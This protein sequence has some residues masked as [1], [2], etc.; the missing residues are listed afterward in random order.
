VITT[1]DKG[2]TPGSGGGF[3]AGFSIRL[4]VF[5]FLAGITASLLWPVQRSIEERMTVARD[6]IIDQAEAYLGRT[7]EY[8]S[9]GP[10][11]LGSLDIRNIRIYGGDSAPVVSVARFRVF[12][13]PWDLFAG[14]I[15]GLI[16]SVRIDRPFVTLDRDRDADL[17]DLFSS[18]SPGRKFSWRDA[19]LPGELSV[20]VLGGG[21]TLTSGENRFALTGLFF[22]AAIQAGRVLI[23]GKWDGELAL[24]DFFNQTAAMTC[25]FNGEFSPDL[26]RGGLTVS[27]PSLRGDTF[28]FRPVTVNLTKTDSLIEL[29]KINDR[30]PF[31]L[32]LNY[33]LGSG[34]LRGEFG[35]EEFAVRDLV[36]LAGAWDAYNPW[37]EGR[38]S[39]RASLRME[40]QNRREPGGM[41]YGFDLSCRFPPNH[42]LE[43]Y[44]LAGRGDGSAVKFDRFF[45]RF[46]Q[47][48]IRFAGDL[49]FKPFSPNG[50]IYISELSLSGDGQVNSEFSV[51]TENGETSVFG[52]SVSLGSVFLSALDARVRYEPEGLTFALSALRFRNMDSY[53][54]VR[55]SSLSLSGSLDYTRH[56]QASLEADFFSAADILDMARPFVRTEG[57]PGIAGEV[58]EDVSVS[59]EVFF[60]T[61]FEHLLYNA[62]RVVIAYEGPRNILAVLSLSGTDRRFDLT[63]GRIIWSGV[64]LETSGYADFSNPQDIAFSLQASYMDLSYFLEGVILDRRSLSLQGSY[65]VSAYISMTDAG[66]FSGYIDAEAVPIPIRGQFAR[67]SL[68]TSLRYASPDFWS[69]DI[70]RLEIADLATPA[71]PFAALSIRGTADQD[72][73]EFPRLL[74][75]DSLGALSGRALVAWERDFSLIRGDLS[76]ADQAAREQY[77]VT[78]TY[79]GGEAE[80]RFTGAGVPLGRFMRN[81][82][83]AL[84]S[85]EIRARWNSAESYSA[86][87]SLSSLSAQ[88]GERELRASGRGEMNQETFAV[89]DLRVN[90]GALQGE[91]PFFRVSLPD[92]RMETEAWIQGTLGGKPLDLSFGA[93]MGFEPVDSWFLMARALNT[94]T[95]SVRVYAAR[96]DTVESPEPFDFHFSRTDALMSL[97]GGPGNMLRLQISR[98]GDFYTGLSYP[99]PVRGTVTGAVTSRTIDAQASNL[100]VDMASL[101]RYIPRKDI[102]S[103]SGGFV[104][105]SVR[106][107]GPLWDPEFFG[108]A[109]GTSIRINIPRFLGE[110][111]GPVPVAIVLEGNEMNFGPLSA[112]VGAGMGTV[113]GWFRFDRWIPNTFTIDISVPQERSIP[114]AVDIMG[115]KAGGSAMGQLKLSMA[116]YILMVS[117]DLNAQDTEIT[118]DA[119]R[120]GQ[121]DPYASS[122]VSVVTDLTIKTGRKVEFVWPVTM[123]ILQAYVDAGE[124]IRISSDNSVDRYSIVGDV[125]LRSG[126][127]YYFQRSFYI[128]EGSLR[129]NENEI[130]FDPRISARA[131]IRDRNDEGPVTIF[132]IL[133]N[134]P[135]LS[136][137][138]RFEAEPPLSQAEIFSFLGQNVTGASNDDESVS[139]A[140]VMASS[141]LL[142]QIGLF[143]QG[144][145][146]IRD[147]FRL[148]MFS[149]RTMVLQNAMLQATGLRNPVDRNGGVGNYFD[150]T[151]VFLGKYIRSDMF[152]QAMVSLRYDA[153]KTTLGGLI[154]EPDIGIEL[155]NPLFSVRWNFLPRHFENLFIDD[156]SFTLTWRWSF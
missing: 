45:F 19:E 44:T 116:D 97:S 106:I 93:E 43:G 96:L 101:W 25:R 82:Y 48:H 132:M 15:P 7:I 23:Q 155:Q 98:E 30:S 63:E 49:G 40:S 86:E 87:L 122:R 70:D 10:S 117:G 21:C 68:L 130:R 50:R 13:S 114:F 59:A 14:N 75:E 20:R 156:L 9:V 42:P 27:V 90:Y 145:R 62:P 76:A 103:F 141:D 6:R 146:Y 26:R 1:A 77:M 60:T 22:E 29:R 111:I 2:E 102:I 36:S 17:I 53:E 67:L 51:S 118:M 91:L 74:Y 79:E 78:G 3:P 100:Y 61:D 66:F 84:M 58:L 89:E 5:V 11:L 57:V 121:P 134:A 128:R 37:L 140:F 149:V 65:G 153:D 39:G 80:L 142:T 138:A 136:F 105:A 71:S 131:E 64:G 46:P 123:P 126:E 52:D 35:A 110:D 108:T 120:L 95:G 56:V 47:G 139:N 137:T 119:Q 135:L 107:A 38:L 55:L 144:E 129:F 115:I 154:I 127:I 72:G 148:D 125:S 151:T 28:R 92:A 12:Y 94:F 73:A 18:F 4:L 143:R 150:R 8:G 133:D 85:G 124:G 31:D 99:S 34:R 32:Y 104:T 113:S 33:D 152:V 69:L 112:P 24:A 83:N 109:Q 81:S 16:R 88:V 54:D 41:D 147:F